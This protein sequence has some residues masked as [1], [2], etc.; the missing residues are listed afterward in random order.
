VWQLKGAESRAFLPDGQSPR[1]ERVAGRDVTVR[2][3]LNKEQAIVDAADRR[4]YAGPNLL[5][6]EKGRYVGVRFLRHG[7]EK[8]D[9]LGVASVVVQKP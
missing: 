1:A 5:S 3:R 2:I 4:L 9:H 6:P 7:G 8:W